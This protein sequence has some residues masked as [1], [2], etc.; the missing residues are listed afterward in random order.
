M[1]R[2]KTKLTTL[3]GAEARLFRIGLGK[4]SFLIDTVGCIESGSEPFERLSGEQQ[5]FIL[6]RISRSL[7]DPEV[8]PE[9]VNAITEASIYAVYRAIQVSLLVEV[10]MGDSQYLRNAVAEAYGQHSPPPASAYDEASWEEAVEAVADQ[11][12]DDRDWQMENHL[13]DANPDEAARVKRAM[14]CDDAYF[15]EIAPEPTDAELAWA[16][17]FLEGASVKEEI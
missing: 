14:G 4:L 8:E 10:E 16:R 1:W 15:T 6:A 7:L 3:T 5:I 17:D 13:C 12:L 11:I 2:T 9:N